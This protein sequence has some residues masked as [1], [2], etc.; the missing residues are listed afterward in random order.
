MS[1]IRFDPEGFIFRKTDVYTVMVRYTVGRSYPCKTHSTVP[2]NSLPEDETSGFE[3]FKC[4]GK[5]KAH[6]RT[7]HEGPEG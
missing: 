7:G 1:S 6:P 5:D 3:T 4:K 2:Y